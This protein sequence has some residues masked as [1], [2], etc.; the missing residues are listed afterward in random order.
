MGHG[1]TPITGTCNLDDEDHFGEQALS[2]VLSQDTRWRQARSCLASIGPLCYRISAR[3]ASP[4]KSLYTVAKARESPGFDAWFGH[5]FS[6]NMAKDPEDIATQDSG[7]MRGKH[8]R[9]MVS[10]G[11][12]QSLV[13]FVSN[14]VLVRWLSPE[15][16]GRYAIAL[17]TIGLVLTIFSMRL[18]VLIIRHPDAAFDETVR[19][20]YEQ[21]ILQEWLVLTLLATGWL[22]LTDL[23]SLWN[24]VLLLA[25]TFM[26]FVGNHKALFE[27]NMAYGTL[28]RMELTASLIGHLVAVVLVMVGVGE[29]ALYLRDLSQVLVAFVWLRML[30]CMR[31]QRIEWMNI[32]QWRTLVKRISGLW[33][34]GILEGL[35]ARARILIAAAV[36]G[37]AG[38]GFFMQAHRLAMVPHQTLAPVVG[39]LALNWFSRDTDPQLRR[40]RRRRIGRLV[41]GPLLLAA[42]AAALLADPVVPWI[43]GERWR[44]VVP[45][46]IALWGVVIFTSLFATH[47]MYLMV[48][49]RIPT[50]LV[51]RVVQLTLLCV[52]LVPLAMNEP[53]SLKATCHMVSLAW[54]LAFCITAVGLARIDREP[55]G[56]PPVI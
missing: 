51:A 49:D 31:W 5:I 16:F 22:W 34:D 20:Q 9:W 47:K 43:F 41:A 8:A 30:G 35:F 13:A 23:W 38:A 19:R 56:S 50:L 12:I 55:S 24:V 42:L 4:G 1:L 28:A 44:P 27:R 48:V 10:S 39:R 37:Q 53:F 40:T 54:M 36:A 26:H 25:L 3:D 17:A 32:S 14:I 2:G 6:D 52:P 11:A 21:S 7:R 45:L 15:E 29:G 33:A 18:S 46:L